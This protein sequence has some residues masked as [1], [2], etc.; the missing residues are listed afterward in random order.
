MNSSRRRV[1]VVVDLDTLR[2]NFIKIAAAVK[3]CAVVA[4]L[5]ANAYGLGVR[6]IA[7]ALAVAG[8]ARFAV[9]EVKEAVEL[10]E[11]GL[12][13]HILGSLLDEEI[14]EALAHGIVLP[15]TDLGLAQR[16]SAEAV[17]QGRTACVHFKID[18]GMGRLGILAAEAE[19]VIEASMR[20]PNLDA[21]G[22]Y[23][24][25]PVAYRSGSVF[26]EGQIRSFLD[27]LSRLE[28]RGIH[29]R[30]RHMANSDAV[31]N[32]PR[33]FQSP[34]NAV[35]TGI[36][37]YG[38]FD[39]EGQRVMDLRSVLTLRTRLTAVRQLP[40]GMTIGY[41]C[42][43]T[44]PRAMR[45]GT[46]SAGYADG[47][48]LALSNRGYVLIRGRPCPVL[49]R[50]SMDYTTVDMTQVPEACVGDDVVC[51]G[52]DG[53]TAVSVEHWAQ[54]KGTHPYDI[55][56]SIGGR[57]ERCYVGTAAGEAEGGVRTVGV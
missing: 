14:P 29:F 20:L 56:C 45:V 31:N 49:G 40:A 52:G 7:R 11:L 24:H 28:A 19:D 16:I 50:V 6:P 25:F 30:L 22:I 18:T 55:I 3:P 43:Y 46:I 44:L 47:L 42:T 39:I 1:Q 15:V 27:L 33:A 54:L 17:R 13:V 41:G 34:L 23:T 4:V 37:L 36:N 38:C 5:K 9:A 48:P 35:R 10:A 53:P 8:A 21:E 32:V 12:P 51:L 2:A 26:T 57:V